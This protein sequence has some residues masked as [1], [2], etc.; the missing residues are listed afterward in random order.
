MVGAWHHTHIIIMLSLIISNIFND[1]AGI[2]TSINFVD[3]TVSENKSH[4]VF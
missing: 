4:N 3:L 2:H 1:K